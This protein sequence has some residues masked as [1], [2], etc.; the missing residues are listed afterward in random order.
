ME[1]V[2]KHLEKAVTGLEPPIEFGGEHDTTLIEWAT[3]ADVAIIERGEKGNWKL[4]NPLKCGGG[5]IS[6]TH[7]DL[8]GDE[9]AEGEEIDE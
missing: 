3:H 7:T 1:H 5:V 4:R 9:D 6:E 8:E 2:A